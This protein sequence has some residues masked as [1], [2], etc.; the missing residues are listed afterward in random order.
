MGNAEYMG[1]GP[2]YW[3]THP[4]T[5]AA[6]SVGNPMVASRSGMDDKFS[7]SGSSVAAISFESYWRLDS[8]SQ[9]SLRSLCNELSAW[10]F[11]QVD[12]MRL[13]LE[14]EATLLREQGE[15]YTFVM[16]PVLW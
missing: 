2:I 13:I 1:R 3:L 5:K 10:S 4:F 9:V 16:V 14:L 8:T 12:Y 7:R 6:R 15:T 11:V